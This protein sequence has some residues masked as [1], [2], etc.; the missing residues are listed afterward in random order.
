MRRKFTLQ[1]RD[2]PLYG[3]LG[4]HYPTLQ[5][6]C[7]A[8]HC[9]EPRMR[10]LSHRNQSHIAL[11]GMTMTMSARC[12]ACDATADFSGFAHP[13]RL[14]PDIVYC[15]N[16]TVWRSRTPRIPDALLK[17]LKVTDP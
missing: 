16:F 11:P 1:L 6:P 2:R 15:R 12:D 14:L 17:D 9:K 10:V 8:P 13:D 5:F 7:P 4:G 3:D